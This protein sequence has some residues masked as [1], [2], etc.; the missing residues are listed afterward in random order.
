MRHRFF[1]FAALAACVLL[2]GCVTGSGLGP[3]ADQALAAHKAKV[4]KDP[5]FTESCEVDGVSVT[6]PPGWVEIPLAPNASPLARHLYIHAERT[7]ASGRLP[8]VRVYLY[9]PETGEMLFKDA[10]AFDALASEHMMLYKNARLEFDGENKIIHHVYKCMMPEVGGMVFRCS[11]I[12]ASRSGVVEVQYT[13]AFE[14]L[15]NSQSYYM[16]VE[17]LMTSITRMY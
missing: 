11:T 10:D 13:D 3:A 16:D 12:L 5:A 7:A 1:L 4:A 14:N 15:A 17:R 2:A 9:P 8:I 6:L